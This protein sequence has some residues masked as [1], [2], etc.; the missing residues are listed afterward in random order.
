MKRKRKEGG[1]HPANRG[2]SVLLMLAWLAV[3]LAACDPAEGRFRV[4]PAASAGN[5]QVLRGD[6]GS[7]LDNRLPLTYWAELNGNAASI[8]SS[9]GEVPFFQEWQRRTGVELDFIQPPGNQGKEALSILLASG[10]LPDLIEYEWIN[11]PGGPEKAINDG[12]ILRLN[13]IKIGRAHV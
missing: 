9:F 10:E 4:N 7:A 3:L 6:G 5:S 1:E 8:K 2:L 12:Y 11:Y 13:E